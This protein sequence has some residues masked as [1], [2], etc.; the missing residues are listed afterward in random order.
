MKKFFK[1]IG[2]I[3]L[4][5]SGGILLLAFVGVFVLLNF[6]ECSRNNDERYSQEEIEEMQEDYTMDHYRHF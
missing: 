1:K 5:V 4:Y 6:M 2:L 3:M